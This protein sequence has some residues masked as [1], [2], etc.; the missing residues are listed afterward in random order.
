MQRQPLLLSV[1]SRQTSPPALWNEVRF[2][3]NLCEAF[4]HTEIR[5]NLIPLSRVPHVC[6]VELAIFQVLHASETSFK[7]RGNGIGMGAG[8]SG[9]EVEV[10]LIPFGEDV[11]QVVESRI[12]RRR[13]NMVWLEVLI[14]Q[15]PAFAETSAFIESGTFAFGGLGGQYIQTLRR[16]AIV[17]YL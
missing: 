9:A 1:S 13:F 14:Y 2:V 10:A 6:E 16:F 12:L 7:C 8:M 3:P 4:V 11:Y 17:H 5:V 15:F